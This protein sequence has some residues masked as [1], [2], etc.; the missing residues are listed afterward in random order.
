MAPSFLTPAAAGTSRLRVQNAAADM[1]KAVEERAARTGV[2]V[3]PYLF[4]EMIGKGSFGQV[5]KW[6]LM[7]SLSLDCY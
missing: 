6:Y 3:P 1:Q 4:L 2:S 5:F 7:V